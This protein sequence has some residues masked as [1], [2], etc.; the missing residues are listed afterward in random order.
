MRANTATLV[1][2]VLTG[3]FLSC[4]DM[5]D[6]F[7]GS[8]AMTSEYRSIPAIKKIELRTNVDV[9]IHPDTFYRVLVK[10]E[11]N[12][13]DEIETSCSDSTLSIRNN[14]RCNWVRKFNPELVVEVWV[15]ELSNIFVESS[16]GNIYFSDTLDSQIFRFDSFDSQGEFNL[17]LNSFIATLAMHT[18]PSDMKV[19]GLAAVQYNY[20]AGF[21][22]MD[23]LGLKSEKIYMNNR[24]TNDV[25]VRASEVIEA[26]IE[27]QGNIYYTGAP[28][29]VKAVV[30]GS[31][32]LIR[33]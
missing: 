7:K 32:K 21:G 25:Y 4:N 13:I 31:G 10:A 14:N 29:S 1:L 8:G 18:G 15:K 9:I 23:C 30:L 2:I 16:D 12:L 5:G 3:L 19:E 17:K 6:C 22:K 27:S 26:K 11:G 24:S 28:V 33:L 20:S